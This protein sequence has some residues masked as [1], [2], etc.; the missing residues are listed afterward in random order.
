MT[1]YFPA[2]GAAPTLLPAGRGQLPVG[3]ELDD[4]PGEERFRAVFSAA[5]GGEG[6]VLLVR[7]RKP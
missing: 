5:P 3:I 1:Q 4:R 2:P 7:L 6:E